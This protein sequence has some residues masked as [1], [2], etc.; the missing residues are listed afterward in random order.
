[1]AV[2]VPTGLLAA[3]REVHAWYF[4]RWSDYGRVVLAK[5]AL[6]LLLGPGA[7]ATALALRRGR[8]AGGALRLEALGALALALL[9]ATLAG[10]VPGRG[11]ALPAQRGNLLV[12]AAFGAA[13][14]RGVGVRLTLAPALPGLNTIA[15]T[16]VVPG[17]A[18]R[19]ERAVAPRPT[20]GA[21]RGACARA[22]VRALL[23]RGRA[24]TW[25]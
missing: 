24:G 25:W 21:P 22:P 10:L 19:A 3:F 18:G 1:V 16:P 13:P 5:S 11:Q 23:R 14:A 2:L 12:G 15:A 17:R 6:L 4:L 7:L 8:A 20:R 9:A